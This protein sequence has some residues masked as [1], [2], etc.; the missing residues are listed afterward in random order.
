M[1]RNKM[2]RENKEIRDKRIDE[3]DI[4]LLKKEIYSLMATQPY[5]IR[6]WAAEMNISHPTLIKFLKTGESISFHSLWKLQTFVN[7]N[8]KW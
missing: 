4:P 2:S 7:V 3:F 5:T 1:K 8:K 6:E